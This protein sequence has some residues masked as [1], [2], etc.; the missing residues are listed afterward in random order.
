MRLFPDVA[1]SRVAEAEALLRRYVR[2]GR[3]AAAAVRAVPA[4]G[5]RS[6][7]DL[8]AGDPDALAGVVR[9]LF[10]LHLLVR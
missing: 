10:D 9:E 8:A 7:R 4:L 5:G 3:L 2:A 1:E 6:L